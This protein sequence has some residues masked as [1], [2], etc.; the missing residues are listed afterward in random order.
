LKLISN[1]QIFQLNEIIIGNANFDVIKDMISQSISTSSTGKRPVEL[2]VENILHQKSFYPLLPN[3]VN[4]EDIEKIEKTITIDERK[5]NEISMGVIPDIFISPISTMQPSVKK[6]SST[7]FINPGYLI[8]NG[9]PGTF[10]RI[11]SYPPDVNL[12]FNIF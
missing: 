6:I 5:L 2:A 9:N 1:P 11:T 3:S 8:K 7:L 10:A 4:S 12:F